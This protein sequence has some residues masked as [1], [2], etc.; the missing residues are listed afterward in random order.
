ME[1]EVS[2]TEKRGNLPLEVVKKAQTEVQS[3]LAV[4][5]E[6]VDRCRPR[7]SGKYALAEDHEINDW[8]SRI[9]EEKRKVEA[10]QLTL[11]FIGTM[12]AGK[13]TCINAIVGAEVLPNRNTPMTVL[14]TVITHVPGCIEPV[15]TFTKNKPFNEAVAALHALCK[16]FEKRG[17]E[18]R[19]PGE[20]GSILSR[21][22]SER[23]T[24]IHEEYRGESGICEFMEAI[25]DIARVCGNPYL[26]VDNP[27]DEYTSIDEFPQ[28]SIEF[29]CLK[30][31]VQ[32]GL[33]KLSLIDTPGPNE[34]GQGHLK[35]VV[36]DQLRRAS[37]IISILDY[38]QL[39]SEADEE[40]RKWITEAQK[41]SGVGLYVFVNKYDCR[42]RT[43]VLADEG[44]LVE[45]VR[46][47]LFPDVIDADKRVLSSVDGRVFPVSAKNAFYGNCALKEIEHAGC[48][49]PIDAN[50]WVEDFGVLAYGSECEEDLMSNDVE[51]HRNAS[52]MLW[53]KSRME[54]P[55]NRVIADSLERVVPLCLDSALTS[56]ATTANALQN[57]LQ[58][59]R[60][61][62]DKTI[63]ELQQAVERMN[64]RLNTIKAVEEASSQLHKKSIHDVEL[65][66][67]ATFAEVEKDILGLLQA[68]AS[69]K[70]RQLER[71]K[72]QIEDQRKQGLSLHWLF[73]SKSPRNE[74]IVQALKGDEPVVFE[75]EE[76][77]KEFLSYLMSQLQ[78]ATQRSLEK[79]L[80]ILRKPI[81]RAGA[82]LSRSIQEQVRPVIEEMGQDAQ[83]LFG[84]SLTI[85]PMEFGSYDVDFS[86]IKKGR[87]R[88]SVESRSYSE[89]RWYTFWLVDHK[90]PY[91]VDKY[92]IDPTGLRDK[93]NDVLS[94]SLESMKGELHSY[95]GNAF[96]ESAKTY[97]LQVGTIFSSVR[98][99]VLGGIELKKC[100]ESEQLGIAKE[101]E[102]LSD[103]VRR[104]ERRAE[105]H[106]EHLD[107]DF[108]LP[109]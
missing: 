10:L 103:T 2:G 82:N 87:I 52:L 4:L 16:D 92:T 54:E 77:A 60:V 81:D 9:R 19:L 50:N 107:A 55:L 85:P 97:F 7:G 21:I 41:S 89:R 66:I 73:G 86:T 3:Q 47:A 56:V 31:R 33:G 68:L 18:L 34:A 74:K 72:K 93:I 64:T 67:S 13:S 23:L 88:H 6:A 109:L 40:V 38:T 90:V 49:P 80:A 96:K 94:K 1:K 70:N 102:A 51:K 104:A 5:L 91:Q 79:S 28:I 100:E 15:L 108:A 46:K 36:K 14:P 20:E 59:R 83:E 27:L 8:M 98:D 84:I 37:A 32:M 105:R 58:V 57:G 95:L 69:K 99:S 76:E 65:Q 39:K 17:K 62:L 44:A 11:A 71:E 48:L 42:K 53:K 24:T 101:I 43:D 12:K 22:R 35:H 25:N 61:S 78:T 45:Y 29:S 106:K 63:N 75:D 26:E 30:D